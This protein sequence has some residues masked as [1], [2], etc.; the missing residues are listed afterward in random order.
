MRGAVRRRDEGVV[1]VEDGEDGGE[2]G[3]PVRVDVVDGG[4]EFDSPF[5]GSYTFLSV[6]ATP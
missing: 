4:D 1:R 5:F 6:I 3:G 2:V